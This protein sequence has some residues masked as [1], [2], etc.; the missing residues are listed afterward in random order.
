MTTQL[1]KAAA[2]KTKTAQSRKLNK[3]GFFR[4]DYALDPD[5]FPYFRPFEG[6]PQDVMHAE[7]SSGAANWE[8]A[9]MLYVFI[10]MEKYFSVDA[11][12]AAI[13]NYSWPDGQ[14]IPAIYAAI[15]RGQK[16][17]GPQHN[18]HLRY[19]G[20]MTLHFVQH[21]IKLLRDLVPDRNHPAW[22]SWKAHVKYIK[23][24][25][26]A[27]FTRDSI[28]ELDEAVSEH[29]RLYALVPQYANQ[30]KPKHHFATHYAQDLL[31]CG[32]GAALMPP[33]HPAPIARPSP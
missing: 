13:A 21:S 6:C 33:P 5:L 9:Q 14:R 3:H 11:L 15:A 28:K 16:G 26:N 32:P 17:G 1:A 24:V 29:H 22:L 19:S 27:T 20:S 30:F 8:A 31:N 18:A 10:S 12:N 25:C 4:L 23:L 2:Q 7:F